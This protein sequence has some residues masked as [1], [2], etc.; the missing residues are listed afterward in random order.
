MRDLITDSPRL[1]VDNM[2]TVAAVASPGRGAGGGS[3]QVTPSRG[4]QPKEKNFCGQNY[5]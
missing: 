4:W 1:I 3:P 5:K 2:R